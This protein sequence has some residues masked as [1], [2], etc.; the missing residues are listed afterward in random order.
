MEP[1]TRSAVS[2]LALS[3]SV[4]DDL[5][6]APRASGSSPPSWRTTGHEA[7]SFRTD[8]RRNLPRFFHPAP[9]PT[10][11]L[12]HRALARVLRSVDC[13]R[14]HADNDVARRGVR[15]PGVGVGRCR[16]LGC[17]E[18]LGQLLELLA[19]HGLAQLREEVGLL[20]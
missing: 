12:A 2:V 4:C 14:G 1:T 18:D 19:L 9:G 13:T 5:A 7:I 20:L 15:R 3:D 10:E 17:V 6:A 16:P 8:T 11:N